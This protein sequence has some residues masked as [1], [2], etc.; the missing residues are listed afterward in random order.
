MLFRA[1][2]GGLTCIC[3]SSPVR[4]CSQVMVWT[5]SSVF[6]ILI[7]LRSSGM[8]AP[9][10]QPCFRVRSYTHHDIFITSTSAKSNH[11]LW[12]LWQCVPYYQNKTSRFVY[13]QKTTEYDPYG[14]VA[15]NVISEVQNLRA[16]P[17]CKPQKLIQV[18]L[19]TD[20]VN[21]SDSG[22]FTE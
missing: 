16:P 2:P 9:V 1:L 8:I 5:Y 15:V 3:S 13:M 18:S 19:A 17:A 20:K 10:L 4:A 12:Y 7:S 22:I 14:K 6:M 21:R 11:C